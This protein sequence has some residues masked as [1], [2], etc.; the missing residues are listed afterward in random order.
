MI[1]QQMKILGNTQKPEVHCLTTIYSEQ[2][3]NNV[4]LPKKTNRMN[5]NKDVYEL[6]DFLIGKRR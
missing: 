4:Q 3:P 5:S 1:Q 6:I 2:Q